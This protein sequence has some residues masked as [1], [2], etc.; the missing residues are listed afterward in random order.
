MR[1]LTIKDRKLTFDGKSAVARWTQELDED[2]KSYHAIDLV[3]EITMALLD[4]LNHQFSLTEEETE[5]C[6]SVLAEHLK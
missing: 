3:S 4:E 6:K 1:T 5:H 2:L